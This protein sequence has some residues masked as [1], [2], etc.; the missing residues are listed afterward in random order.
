MNTDSDCRAHPTFRTLGFPAVPGAVLE[1][2]PVLVAD[3]EETLVAAVLHLV[4]HPVAAHCHYRAVGDGRGT[5]AP[6]HRRHA[7]G[8]NTARANAAS[9]AR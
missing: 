1:A 8:E 3:E 7:W 2:L 4:A 5:L 9:A 6:R